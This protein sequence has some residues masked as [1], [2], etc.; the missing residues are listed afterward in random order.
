M[1][2]PARGCCPKIRPGAADRWF[3][4][5]YFKDLPGPIAPEIS[6]SRWTA[7]QA[8]FLP[9]QPITRPGSGPNYTVASAPGA[10]RARPLQGRGFL[11]INWV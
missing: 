5:V 6:P 9:G 10:A 3:R 4:V 11:P 7:L 8:L 1:E 2:Q